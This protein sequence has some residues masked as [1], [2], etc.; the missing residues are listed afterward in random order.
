M[1]SQSAIERAPHR[2]Q[3]AMFT[4]IG[5]AG[6]AELVEK[7]LT[8]AITGGH[9]RA[10]DRLPSE[11]DLA[12]TMGV[13]PVTV[14]EALLGLRGRGLVVTRRGRHGGSFVSETADP[15]AFAREALRAS[16]RL[17][18]RDLGVHYGALTMAGVRLAARRAAPPE[19]VAVRSR[20]ARLDTDDPAGWRQ[21]MDDV[22]LEL[23]ALSQSARI[24]RDQMRLQ[25]E[26]SPFLRLIDIDAAQRARQRTSFERVLDAVETG[27]EAAASEATER[28]VDET[29]RAL[30]ALHM[31]QPE[32]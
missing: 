24:T 28:M 20:L 25:A 3:G 14:R 9:L 27:D 26:L 23:V 21:S 6:R 8:D 16:S 31:N 22:Q 12:R 7:R 32:T 10:G 30:D 15:I 1:T 11:A 17:A 29:I 2:L 13:S 18:L 19:L 5:D 4:P